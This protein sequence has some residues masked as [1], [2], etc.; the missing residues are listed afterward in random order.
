KLAHSK[1]ITLRQAAADLGLVRP[2][3]FDTFVRPENMVSPG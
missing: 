3:D 2:E 1:N